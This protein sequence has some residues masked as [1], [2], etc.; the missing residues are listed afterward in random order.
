[1]TND[2][3]KNERLKREIGEELYEKFSLFA[4][5]L[6]A[7]LDMDD[8]E[9]CD[10]PED[11]ICFSEEYCFGRS[12]TR[13]DGT[14]FLHLNERVG[15]NCCGDYAFVDGLW[16]DIEGDKTWDSETGDFSDGYPELF[17]LDDSEDPV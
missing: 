1:M 7:E 8:Y 17:V 3:L 9:G 5:A 15:G 14:V 13:A 12:W 4:E 11:V 10:S 6:R 16:I 2:V